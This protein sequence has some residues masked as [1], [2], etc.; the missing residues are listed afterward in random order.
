MKY[1]RYIVCLLSLCFCFAVNAATTEMKD[2]FS[3][4]DLNRPGLE[5]VKMYCE[6]QQWEKLM[7]E[8][9]DGAMLVA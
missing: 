9:Q 6:K 7:K 3:L 2:V 8:L 4:L 1:L 5:K